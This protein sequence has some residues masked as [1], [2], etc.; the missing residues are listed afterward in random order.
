[1]VSYGAPRI[2]LKGSVENGI[3]IFE[4]ANVQLILKYQMMMKY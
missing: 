2:D 3:V 1:M 4:R